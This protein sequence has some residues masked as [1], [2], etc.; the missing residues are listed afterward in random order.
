[1]QCSLIIL[2]TKMKGEEKM[3]TDMIT[4]KSLILFLRKVRDVWKKT[5]NFELMSDAHFIHFLNDTL[6][7]IFCDDFISNNDAPINE[8]CTRLYEQYLT[9]K[10]RATINV[11]NHTA[12]AD[13]F[14]ACMIKTCLRIIKYN[15]VIFDES[16]KKKSAFFDTSAFDLMRID[17][18]IDPQN[19][20]YITLSQL[21]KKTLFTTTISLLEYPCPI[22]NF[23]AQAPHLYYNSEFKPLL[24]LK[25]ESYIASINNFIYKYVSKCQTE[26][27]TFFDGREKADYMYIGEYMTDFPS[28]VTPRF[29]SL[30]ESFCK[31]REIQSK[32]YSGY[33]IIY[34]MEF[35]PTRAYGLVIENKI[36]IFEKV[37]GIGYALVGFF[38]GTI[39]KGL[40]HD[41]F[42]TGTVSDRFISDVLARA[43]GFFNSLLTIDDLN[44]ILKTETSAAEGQKEKEYR[45]AE[46]MLHYVLKETEPTTPKFIIYP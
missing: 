40:K 1:M 31:A 11:Y 46:H 10:R 18:D 21:E 43:H 32:L 12:L 45:L 38:R 7:T 28:T 17:E 5:G 4:G 22:T 2:I 6:F 15:L 26:A 33:E 29:K 3:S 19:W 23:R 9:E 13:Y 35:Y 44:K 20:T 37:E 30:F 42:Y 27:T 25:P 36:Y 8:I 39:D 41:A 24:I 14:K 16:S 34:S